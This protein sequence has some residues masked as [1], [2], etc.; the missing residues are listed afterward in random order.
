MVNLSVID[1]VVR[2]E[3]VG[4]RKLLAFTSRF[5]IAIDCIIRAGMGSPGLPRFL[6]SD[7]R[8]LGT[9][10]PGRFAYGRFSMGKPLRSAFLD[11]SY[12]SQQ[13]IVLELRNSTFD[14]VMVEV[15]DARRAVRQIA[16]AQS[17]LPLRAAG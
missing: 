1:N 14:L 15:E 6:A 10:I 9:S 13:V 11:L 4:W 12:R 5:D 17:A 16:D 2:V 8:T 3:V 7:R